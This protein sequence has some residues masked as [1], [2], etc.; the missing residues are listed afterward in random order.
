MSEQAKKDELKPCP[1]CGSKP[2]SCGYSDSEQTE[3]DAIQCDECN[4]S[5]L[6]KV[7]QTRAVKSDDSAIDVVAKAISSFHTRNS[8]ETSQNEWQECCR[9]EARCVIAAMEDFI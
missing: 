8:W 6:R 2:V 5:L 4:F 3:Y 1:F 7:W 9:N